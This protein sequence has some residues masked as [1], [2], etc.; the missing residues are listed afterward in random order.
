MRRSVSPASLGVVGLVLIVVGTVWAGYCASA[1]PLFFLLT[2]VLLPPPPRW[3]V[4]LAL[5]CF[6]VLT[7]CLLN[8]GR[9]PG[10]WSKRS[11]A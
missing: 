7:G 11:D 4:A 3:L 10:Q 5:V 1:S 9:P 8:S 6:A 2:W